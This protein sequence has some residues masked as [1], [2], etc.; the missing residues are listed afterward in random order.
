MIWDALEFNKLKWYAKG[1][2]Y[3]KIYI[4]KIKALLSF[5][6]P[7][8][9]EKEIMRVH[10]VTSSKLYIVGLLVIKF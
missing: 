4:S 3:I 10:G 2:W 5:N 8:K 9:G 6:T 1:K 7:Y